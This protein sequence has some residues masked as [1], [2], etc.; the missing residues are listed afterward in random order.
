V[1]NF[2]I[3]QKWISKNEPNLGIGQVIKCDFRTVTLLFPISGELR[4][5]NSKAKP[6]LKRYIL[7][8]GEKAISAKGIS[9]FV[10]EIIEE[11]G[12]LHYK[13]KDK[14]LSEALL[15]FRQQTEDSHDK[16]LQNFMEKNFGSNFEFNL[17]EQAAKLQ[18]R[19]KSSMARGMLGPRI[20]ILPHQL[21]LCHRAVSA[22]SL[23]RLM[24]SDEVGLGK[25]IES[26]MIWNALQTE[27]RIKKTLIIVPEQ[28]K[29]QWLI[30]FG[31]RFNNWFAGMDENYMEFSL[32][33]N[34]LCSMEFL[35][36]NRYALHNVSE[37]NWDL[38][39]VDEAHRLIKTASGT[40]EEYSIIEKLSEKIPGLLL[41]SGTPIQLAPE[42]YFYRLK[43]LDSARFRNWEDFEKNSDNYKRIAKDLSKI[44][45]D[46]DAELSWESLQKNIPK[47]SPI[48]SWLPIKADLSL[49]ATE[50]MRRVIDALGTGS[51]VFRN[52]RKSV[53]GFPRRILKTYPLKASG[54]DWLVS[55][56]AE[57]KDEK[58]LL[59]CSSSATVVAL[60]ALFKEGAAVAF[61][62]EESSLERDKAVAAWMQKDGP[63]VLLS[64]EIGSEGRN[65]Q[66]AR[67]LVLFDLPEDSS[68][69]EQRIGRLDR[70]G[71]GEEIYIHVPFME[72]SK[73]EMLFL[74][75]HEAL[76]IFEHSLMGGGEIYAKFEKELKSYLENPAKKMGKFKKEFLPRG[77]EE[78]KLLNQ[79]AEE[80]R[81]RLLEFNSQNK[82]LSEELLAESINMDSNKELLDFAFK[83]LE[84]LDIDAQKGIYPNSF[85]LK[86]APEH[87]E[88][89]TILGVNNSHHTENG[90]ISESD[91]CS[92]TVICDR[93]E[94]LNYENIEFFHWEHPIM[95]RLF[96]KALGED[97]GI[98]ASGI[99]EL[100]PQGEFWIQYNFILDFSVNSRW[101]ISHL[102]SE[103][104]LSVIMD[105][106]G[107]LKN[108][109]QD[110]ENCDLKNFKADIPDSVMEFFVTEG[111]EIA[112]DSLKPAMK[113]ISEETEKLAIPTL[114]SE[115]HR[116]EETY[117]LLRNFELGQI[118]DKKKKDIFT[119]KKSIENPKLRLNGI[120]VLLGT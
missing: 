48:R 40:N 28:L 7:K 71:Q 115:L 78:M 60:L 47:N 4:I 36:F 12:I 54:E 80:G 63:N 15:N 41:L 53:K 102:M 75:Y 111:F 13:N 24:L 8:I 39:I 105:S 62:E 29:N 46:S 6:P 45:L 107:N 72:K 42:A 34:V 114:A 66:S 23:P 10:E 25:T 94:A 118:L 57:H 51:S 109:L 98:L 17:R 38:L 100:V 68:L 56:V 87:P 96:D 82:K 1:P 85:V 26:G 99:H 86:G 117:M 113:K 55:F 69:L 22:T 20:R 33:D 89:A 119:C 81:D 2:A 112:K 73:T 14:I 83:M 27:G 43:L 18:N 5:Y 88:H 44:P 110:F 67:H 92:I 9:L 90:E 77:K 65:F 64:S 50:W 74:W 97:F 84:C 3:G 79:K 101:G 52:T 93:I 58:I 116:L 31:K 21:Y 32:H 11:N 76:G 120:R 37:I 49:T 16:I 61:K 19:W 91:G 30:E 95:R 108:N 103:H 59:I 35:M 106:A 104:F 70:I